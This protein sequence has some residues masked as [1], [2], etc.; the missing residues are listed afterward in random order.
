MQNKSKSLKI[1]FK[2]LRWKRSRN[3]HDLNK[4]HR[5]YPAIKHYL[6]LL[7]M[8]PSSITIVLVLVFRKHISDNPMHNSNKQ[9]PLI[10]RELL[11]TLIRSIR[12]IMVTCWIHSPHIHS[13][14]TLCINCDNSKCPWWIYMQT[15]WW[16]YCSELINFSRASMKWAF[17]EQGL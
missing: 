8:N 12:G 7:F 15:H 9:A 3:S 5:M 14:S 10:Q 17:R 4:K 16:R 11:F 2:A 13:E 6:A 1:Y